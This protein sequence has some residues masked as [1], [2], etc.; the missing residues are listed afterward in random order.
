MDQ[1]P[2]EDQTEQNQE[3]FLNRW[4]IFSAKCEISFSRDTFH[5]TAALISSFLLLSLCFLRERDIVKDQW[6]LYDGW[7]EPAGDMYRELTG[8]N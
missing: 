2:V 7:V 8:W 6:G 1:I 5:F 4:N 3:D